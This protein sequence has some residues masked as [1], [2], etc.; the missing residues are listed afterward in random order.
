[1][2]LNVAHTPPA[3]ARLRARNQ[4]TL[5][6][7]IVQAAGLDE[8]DRFVVDIDPDEP[9]VVRLRR[10]RSSYAGALAAVYGDAEATL[11]EERGS[12]PETR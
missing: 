1:M 9:D 12:W 6:D 5:P 7:P 3:E 11:A 4:L 10:V 8:G 2:A